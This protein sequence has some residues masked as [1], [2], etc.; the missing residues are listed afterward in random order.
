M[1]V[2][3]LITNRVRRLLT[4]PATGFMA[5][6]V[7]VSATALPAS[8]D[9][10]SAIA[11]G[12]AAFENSRD[13]CH[14]DPSVGKVLNEY[15]DLLSQSSAGSRWRYS[16][17]KA[18]RDAPLVTNQLNNT[19]QLLQRGEG[20]D[21]YCKNQGLIMM[22]ALLAASLGG[23]GINEE[24]GN[25]LG[26][27][28]AGG[29]RDK[30]TAAPLAQPRPSF[31]SPRFG[32]SADGSSAATTNPAPKIVP[33]STSTVPSR[34]PRGHDA[35]AAISGLWAKSEADCLDEDGPN[36]RTLIDFDS[37]KTG[38]LFDQYENHCTIDR[39]TTGNPT[40]LTLTC[41]EFW[42]YFSKKKEGEQRQAYITPMADASIK[43]NGE[44]FLRCARRQAGGGRGS[45]ASAVPVALAC[46]A[47][48]F[49]SVRAGGRHGPALSPPV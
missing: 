37:P 17:E 5:V 27:L 35:K 12:Y 45:T 4:H 24:A 23:T 1:R 13:R 38:P 14:Y 7:A 20:G 49:C 31:P 3:A 39:T 41:Y 22:H 42:E 15:S 16:L 9:N 32:S 36:S 6:A 2:H 26:R 28:S 19:A 48:D 11:L 34:S 46:K 10:L 47:L 44:R 43:I 21:Q 33:P 25:E 30:G 18:R 8:A 29:G 40:Q